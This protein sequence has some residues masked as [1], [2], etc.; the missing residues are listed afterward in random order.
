MIKKLVRKKLVNYINQTTTAK[1]DII[2]SYRWNHQDFLKRKVYKIYYILNVQ[3][4]FRTY[5]TC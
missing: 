4:S 2:K 5:S 1:V 3:I